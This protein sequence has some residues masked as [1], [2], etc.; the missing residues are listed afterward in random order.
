MA[1]DL[2][3]YFVYCLVLYHSRM[4]RVLAVFLGTRRGLWNIN[5]NNVIAFADGLTLDSSRPLRA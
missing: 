2:W 5:L 3:I 4:Y 1:F